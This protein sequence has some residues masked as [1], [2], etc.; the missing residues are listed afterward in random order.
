M[1]SIFKFIVKNG[2]ELSISNIELHDL[3]NSSIAFLKDKEFKRC[4]VLSSVFYH[5]Y[6]DN[7]KLES[8][9]II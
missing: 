6:C 1:V 2:H 5:L 3:I 9:I 8:M 4:K 7:I